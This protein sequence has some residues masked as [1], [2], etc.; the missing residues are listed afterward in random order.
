MYHFLKEVA[1]KIAPALSVIFQ[2]S[3]NQGALPDI[4]KSALVVK[5]VRKIL[6]IIV[7]LICICSKIMEHIIYSCTFEHLNQ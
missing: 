4:W 7:L 3:L 2:A 5:A 6:A 1:N